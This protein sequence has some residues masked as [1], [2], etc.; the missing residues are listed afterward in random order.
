MPPFVQALDCE[1]GANNRWQIIIYS[2][3]LFM[4]SIL[5]YTFST[6]NELPQQPPKKRTTRKQPGNG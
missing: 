1:F 5:L 6:I 4:F 2:L 3:R